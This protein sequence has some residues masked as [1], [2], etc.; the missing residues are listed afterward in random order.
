MK[1]TGYVFKKNFTYVSF[2]F[3][4][5]YIK[6]N[7]VD[8]LKYMFLL[9]IESQKAQQHKS[10][11]FS[12]INDVCLIINILYTCAFRIMLKLMLV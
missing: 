2:M 7:F 5:K 11:T 3:M 8:I 10:F 1:Q 6:D 9:R 4:F 12:V